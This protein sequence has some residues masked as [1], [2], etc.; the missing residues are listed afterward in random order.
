MCDQGHLLT[1]D[2]QGREIRNKGL[3]MLVENAY[4][5]SNNVISSMRSKEK[6]VI[7]DKYMRVYYR[8][9]EWAI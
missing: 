6:N 8:I 2:S 7:W 5:T 1:F 4:R 9:E 3:G